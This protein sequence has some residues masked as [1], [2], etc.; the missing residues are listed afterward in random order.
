MKLM[1]ANASG[2]QAFDTP[3]GGGGGGGGE[4]SLTNV[5]THIISK[6]SATLAK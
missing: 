3:R 5:Y 6:N 1:D 2:T 4:E